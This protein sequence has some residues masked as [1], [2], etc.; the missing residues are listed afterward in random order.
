[1]TPLRA[2]KTFFSSSPVPLD[3][4]SACFTLALFQAQ[5]PLALTVRKRKFSVHELPG[6]FVVILGNG[7]QH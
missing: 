6:L 3:S 5:T 1:M 4:V 2:R 7:R